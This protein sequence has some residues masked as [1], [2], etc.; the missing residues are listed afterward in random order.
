VYALVRHDDHTHLAY[1][2]E[3][4]SKPGEV[5]EELEILPEASYIITVKNPEQPSPPG[6]G[7][8]EAQQAELPNRLEARFRGRRFV[9]VDPPEF[10]DP[11]GAELILIGAGRGRDG[12]TGDRSGSAA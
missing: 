12:G 9:P 4:P 11:E 10:L 1:A 5:Q 2:L 6:V 7:L 8:D 3:L